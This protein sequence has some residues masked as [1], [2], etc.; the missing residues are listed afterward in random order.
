MR[1]I[2]IR[3]FIFGCKIDSI[4]PPE[5]GL[6]FGLPVLAL[7]IGTLSTAWRIRKEAKISESIEQISNE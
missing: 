3:N 2:K 5:V 7:G 6:F 1:P 4:I